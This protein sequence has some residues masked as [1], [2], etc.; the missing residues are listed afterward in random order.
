VDAAEQLYVAL[1]H[2]AARLRSLDEEIGLSSARFSVL[3]T[4][5]YEGPQR[6][7]ELARRENVAQPT[8]TQ[9]VQ[10]LEA[11][12]LALRH[13]DSS[14]ARGCVVHLTPAGRSLVRRARA[15]KIRWIGDALTELRADELDALRRAAA[16]LDHRA[17]EPE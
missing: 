1:Q 17:R 14:D 12:R 15:R 5:R 16:R 13:P 11:E 7:G 4:L 6:L 10:R 3:A 8:M 2:A 9:S